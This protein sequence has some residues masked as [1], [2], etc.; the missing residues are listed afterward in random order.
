[1]K[2]TIKNP[3]ELCA[4]RFHKAFSHI[5]ILEEE[6]GEIPFHLKNIRNY[7]PFDSKVNRAM[8]DIVI[9][10]QKVYGSISEL[11]DRITDI[12]NDNNVEDYG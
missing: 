8:K 3:E 10:V 5:N 1:M 9:N 2:D 12:K 4:K 6:L 11:R 7:V